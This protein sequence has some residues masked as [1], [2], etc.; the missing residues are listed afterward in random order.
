MRKILV[1]IAIMLVVSLGLSLV[2]RNTVPASAGGDVEKNI[3]QPKDDEPGNDEPGNDEPGNDEPDD[4]NFISKT[5]TISNI[6]DLDNYCLGYGYHFSA[7]ISNNTIVCLDE[8]QYSSSLRSDFVTYFQN[9]NEIIFTFVDVPDGV[10]LFSIYISNDNH[11]YVYFATSDMTWSEWVES[12]YNK[13]YNLKF[14]SGSLGNPTLQYL[15]WVNSNNSIILSRDGGG[16]FIE[17]DDILVSDVISAGMIYV[18][19]QN[20]DMGN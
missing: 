17:I 15:K 4:N 6:D 11:S 8:N 14:Y 19:Y 18:A 1:F 2:A 3:E 20:V 5:V 16:S 7:V 10:I 13:N 9:N 12:D